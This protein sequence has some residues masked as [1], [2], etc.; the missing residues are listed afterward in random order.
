MILFDLHIELCVQQ[1]LFEYKLN[2]TDR[3]LVLNMSWMEVKGTRFQPEIH[4][5]LAV[6]LGTSL[7]L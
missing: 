5:C 4:Y 2:A 6:T 7:K 1:M 3:C